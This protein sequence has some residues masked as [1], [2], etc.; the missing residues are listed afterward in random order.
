MV[1]CVT[2]YA[3]GGVWTFSCH[4]SRLEAMEAQQFLLEPGGF[5]SGSILAKTTHFSVLW[6]WAHIPHIWV[7]SVVG[8]ELAS[9]FTKDSFC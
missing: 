9:L 4:V 5:A 6:N 8:G 7:L 1:S 3:K 2:D